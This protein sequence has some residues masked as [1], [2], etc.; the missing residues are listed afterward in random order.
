MID[1]NIRTEAVCEFLPSPAGGITSDLAAFFC[2]LVEWLVGSPRGAGGEGLCA[3]NKSCCCAT[4]LT[5][6][7]MEQL[8]IRLDWQTTPA[9]SLVISRL[10]ARGL[11]L[12]LKD[13]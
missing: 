11:V 13:D 10:R 3:P 8:A 5:L 7:L 2:S 6:T 12:E 9:K 1:L 4:T